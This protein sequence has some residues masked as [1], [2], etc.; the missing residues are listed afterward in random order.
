[1]F[2]RIETKCRSDLSVQTKI[3]NFLV[4]L[5]IPFWCI[6]VYASKCYKFAFIKNTQQNL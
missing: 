5:E 4:N 2:E 1:M 6:G 3:C